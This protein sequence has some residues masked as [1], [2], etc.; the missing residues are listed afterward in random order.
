MDILSNFSESL[1]ELMDEKK[2]TADALGKAVGVSDSMIC[3]W[4]EGKYK[5]HLANALKLADYFGCSVEYLMGRKNMKL[6]YVPRVCPPF[7]DRLM[8]VMKNEGKSRYRIVKDTDFSNGHFT[9]WK[10][11]ADP[12]VETLVNL[13]DYLNCTLDYLVGREN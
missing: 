6:D 3:Y 13:A 5:L 2:L 7:H 9:K 4:K 1:S 10:K 8:Q 12:L 11:G